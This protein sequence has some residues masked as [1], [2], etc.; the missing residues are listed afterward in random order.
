VRQRADEPDAARASF[1]S[2]WT[3]ML[4]GF[5]THSVI[6]FYLVALAAHAAFVTLR[7]RRLLPRVRDLAA[8]GAI[9]LAMVGPWYGWLW[10]TFGAEKMQVTPRTTFTPDVDRADILSMMVYNVA[11][12]FYP[13]A[14]FE[15]WPA[16]AQTASASWASLYQGLTGLY[17]SMLPGA[18]TIS[19]SLF[20]LGWAGLAIRRRPERTGP[21]DPAT[22]AASC[23][24]LLGA[25][26][27]VALHPVRSPWGV[28][29]SAFFPSVFALIGF[30]WGAASR[31][32]RP[33][34]AAAASGAVLEFLA[35]FWSH[36]WYVI[37]DPRVLEPP[38]ANPSYKYDTRITF[39]WDDLGPAVAAFL[40]AA[41]LVEAALCWMLA[42]ELYPRRARGTE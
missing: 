15:R 40:A 22:T 10:Q 24:V 28:A 2:F 39:L 36:R 41:I 33:W 30:A 16:L 27:A 37:H 12:S 9:S 19:L 5:L 3:S 23:F 17:F 38:L 29:H 34:V 13:A 25:L 1:L 42:R 8:L 20:F 18:I 26:G 31:A 7:D 35:M 14:L 21:S 6:F 32:P 4:L 11:V